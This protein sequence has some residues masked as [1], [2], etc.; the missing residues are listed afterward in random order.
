[1]F[2]GRLEPDKGADLLAEAA[3]RAGVPLR[4][5]GRGP[6]AT[7]LAAKY[8]EVEQ[9]GWK[10]RT[11]IADLITDARC[12]VMP[13]R[14]RETFGLAAMEALTSGVPVIVSE[15]A[16]IAD[17]ITVGG[18]G[19]S[20][21]P[22]DIDALTTTLQRI[23]SDNVLVATMSHAAYKNAHRLCLAPNDWIDALLSIYGELVAP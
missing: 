2:V 4:V 14:W 6:L 7:P 19:L 1:M 21:N 8:P 18:F 3:R 17:D 13:S 22:F 10:S 11:E 12:L 20:C 16:M 23:A 9:L 5:V 15:N